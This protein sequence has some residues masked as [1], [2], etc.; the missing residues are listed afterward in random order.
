MGV[1]ECIIKQESLILE[2]EDDLLLFIIKLCEQNNIY[3]LLFEHVWLEYCSVESISKFV[4]YIDDHVCKDNHLKSIIKCINRRLIQEQIP[5]Q[6]KKEKRYIHFSLESTCEYN[7]D[8]PLNGILRKENGNDNIEMKASSE[9]NGNVYD[10]IKQTFD[11]DVNFCTSSDDQ[12]PW[13]E[14][15]IKNHKS[16]TITKYV[17][18]G[19]KTFNEQLQTWKLEGR[20]VINGDWIELDSHQNEP[21][22]LLELRDFPINCNDK[23]DAVRLTQMGYNTDNENALRIDAFDIFGN[24]YMIS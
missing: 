6:E 8:D 16:F 22:D 21:I 18:R 7:E 4:Q 3:E 13:I 24:I 17:I 11:F 20:R 15:K 19:N 12:G 5:M 1:I 23:L 14:G 10:L 2:T 9:C